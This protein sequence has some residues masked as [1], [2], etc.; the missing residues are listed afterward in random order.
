MTATIAFTARNRK[1]I[2]RDPVSIILGLGMPLSLLVLFSTIG[3]QVP[4]PSFRIENFAP[5]MIVF[6]FTFVTMFIA[7]LIANDRQSALLLRL[8]A[9][10]LTAMQYVWGY[11]SSLFPL[12][13][14]QGIAGFVVAALLGLTPSLNMLLAVAVLIPTILMSIFLGLVFGSLLGVRQLQ[15]LSG[16]YISVAALL[17]GAWMPVEIMGAFLK[18][19]AEL[20]PFTHAVTAA[21]YALAGEGSALLP[22]LLW[23]VGYALLTAF[24]AVWAFQKL[25]RRNL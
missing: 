8:F 9:S 21:R 14:L 4:N 5:G 11:A 18:T 1:E 23:T 24:L 17:S 25:T 13:L 6:A 10:P 20:L 2:L 7:T 19:V 12:A 15:G 3:R 16:L 22:H